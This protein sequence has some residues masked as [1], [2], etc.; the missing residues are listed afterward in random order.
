MPVTTYLSDQD[1]RSWQLVPEDKDCDELLQDLRRQ[2]GK[3]WLISVHNHPKWKLAWHRLWPVKTEE[4]F[5]AYTLYADCHGEW[6]IINLVTPSGGSVFGASCR[7]D[8]MNFML[9][10]LAGIHHVRKQAQ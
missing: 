6:Q 1:V 8:V 4:I 9:G 3:N 10:Y 2:T 5:K 7:E